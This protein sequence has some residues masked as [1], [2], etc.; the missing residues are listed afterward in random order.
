M[1]WKRLG[2]LLGAV[3]LA[4]SA[5]IYPGVALGD[6]GGGDGFSLA[7][8][9]IT[10]PE[11]AADPDCE[12]MGSLTYSQQSYDHT[13]TFAY[14]DSAA[15]AAWVSTP[16]DDAACGGQWQA[17]W[18]KDWLQDHSTCDPDW[19]WTGTERAD[20]AGFG[21]LTF[22]TQSASAFDFVTNPGRFYYGD[23]QRTSLNCSPNTSWTVSNEH[24]GNI[25]AYGP[26]RCR[27][28]TWGVISGDV[29]AVVYH[30]TQQGADFPTGSNDTLV[31]FDVR[32]RR[33]DCD[34]KIDSDS[35]GIS[36]CDEYDLNTDPSNPID[37]TSG[38]VAFDWQASIDDGDTSVT[39]DPSASHLPKGASIR[40]TFG[41][42][43]RANRLKITPFRH[44][45]PEAG[46]YDVVATLVCGDCQPSSASATVVADPVTSYAPEVRLHPDETHLPATPRWFAKHSSL[47]W[48]HDGCHDD[49]V[50]STPSLARLGRASDHP[51]THQT[52]SVLCRHHGK[53]WRADQLTRPFNPEGR[54]AAIDMR[55]ER[56]EGFYLDLKSG[57]RDGESAK[58]PMTYN[59]KSGQYIT[60]WLF[61]AFDPKVGTLGHTFVRHEGDWERLIVRL[62]RHNAAKTALYFQHECD[63]EPH[64]WSEMR[65]GS[66]L[67]A[68]T[69]PIVYSALGA[70]ASYLTPVD[71]RHAQACDKF[72]QGRGDVAED[73]GKKWKSWK[74]G[75]INAAD[76]PWYGFGG[77]W[78]ETS[79]PA[80]GTFILRSESTG[81]LGPPHKD[82][83]SGVFT[84]R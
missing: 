21:T 20:D 73:G 40:W 61:Y 67:V 51:Y 4:A 2:V 26:D 37:D 55:G 75:F 56:G 48:A 76:E 17:W 19:S 33:T 65:S 78:G 64:A 1:G 79:A 36:D 7:P 68:Q 11:P 69:H 41:D 72:L 66:H 83:G 84:K 32:M 34:P 58:V 25:K 35:G 38:V 54:P 30:C 15:G 29:Q 81:P 52:K 8:P 45:Y 71:L 60:Y 16:R 28:S 13:G 63:G 46:E 5:L 77:A 12:W 62:N 44:V 23:E 74:H 82:P 22:T 59:A 18:Y 53:K 49:V 50:D 10:L 47:K 14:V 31:T 3:G 24:S 9:Q 42:G 39:F 43:T 70:H 6:D 80:S 27:S 57:Y